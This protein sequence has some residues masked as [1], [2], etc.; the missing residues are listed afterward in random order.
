MRIPP[1]PPIGHVIAYEYLWSSKS[2]KREDG[3]KVYPAAIVLARRDLGPTPVAYV[4]GISHM[5]PDTGRRAI[6][7]PRKLKRF[8]GLDEEPS[9]IYTDELNI[10]VWPGPD[11]RPANWL[12][13]RSPKDDCIIGHLPDDWFKELVEHLAESRRMG[14]VRMIKRSE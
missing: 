8:L 11:L 6:E 1:D 2:G 13:R 14:R 9:W 5:P 7:V 4:L 10:F 12:S 3:E